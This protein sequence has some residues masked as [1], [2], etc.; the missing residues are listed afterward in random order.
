MSEL[1]DIQKPSNRLELAKFFGDTSLSAGKISFKITYTNT[2]GNRDIDQ[3]FLDF[4][5]KHSNNEYLAGI[6][7]LLESYSRL[8]DRMMMENYLKMLEL[9]IIDLE[10]KIES[11]PEPQKDLWKDDKKEVKTF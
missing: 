9:R 2:E 10:Q 8:Q 11:K 5:Y 4:C 6:G 7:L 3:R 1:I